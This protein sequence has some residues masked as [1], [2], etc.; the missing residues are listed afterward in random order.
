MGLAYAVSAFEK[1]AENPLLSF[2][3]L[4][5]PDWSFDTILKFAAENKYAGVEIRGIQ[6]QLDLTKCPEFKTIENIITTGNRVE[7]KGLRI[8]DLGSSC[9]LH[10]ADNATRTKNLDEGKKFIDLAQQLNCPNIRVFPNK[11]PNDDQRNATID[12]I[13]KGLLE[14]G[15]YAKG[16][17]VNV[18]LESHGDAVQT[19]ELK[20]MMDSAAHPQVG[21][22]WDIVNM[23]SVTKE[24]PASVYELLKKYIRH[25][26]I[27]DGRM[28]DGQ[29][30]YTLVGKGETPIFE[31]V[32]AL[33][34]GGYKGYYSFEWEKLWH[35]EIDEPE[36]ALTDYPKAMKQHF[37]GK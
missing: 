23:W 28:V 9:E 26:H 6:R 19:V 13:I 14:L 16:T 20:K 3:T 27:K 32:D 1:P 4:G 25:T 11:L 8:V 24:S 34:K 22:V 21:L 12:L 31:A 2:S 36:I 30:H 15:D 29:I 7:A 17:Q 5:C 33:S 37:M 35:P 18:L 10:H